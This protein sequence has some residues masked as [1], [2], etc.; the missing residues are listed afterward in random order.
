MAF[1]GTDDFLNRTG[2]PA[3]PQLTVAFVG[4]GGG[5]AK[6]YFAYAATSGGGSGGSVLVQQ[7]IST[8]IQSAYFNAASTSRVLPTVAGATRRVVAA[9]DS[10]VGATAAQALYVNSVA[11]GSYAASGASN[12][13]MITAA[14]GA[15]GANATGTTA[16]FDGSIAEVLVYNRALSGAEI[17]AVDTWLK[18]RYR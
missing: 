3:W 12:G 15:I 7:D 10:S 13:P 1:D 6:R 4:R 5:S 8:Q 2:L 14:I 17:I 16:F 9:F 11:S 18:Y